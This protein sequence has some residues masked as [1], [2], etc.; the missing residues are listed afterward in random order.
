MEVT[1]YYCPETL[2]ST[3]GYGLGRGARAITLATVETINPLK[4]G[5]VVAV[6]WGG[7]AA[8]LNTKKYKTG[9]ITKRGALLDTAGESAGMGVAAGLGLVVSNAIRVSA[10]A[11]STSTVVPF[12][13]GVLTTASA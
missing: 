6:A 4:A 5:A 1:D 3:V 7:I 12:T 8:L 11:L 10:I 13:L 9:V 2:T